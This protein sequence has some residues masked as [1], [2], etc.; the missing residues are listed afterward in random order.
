MPD[1]TRLP[2][3]R[4]R[5]QESRF[6]CPFHDRD[7]WNV[8]PLPV[9]EIVTGWSSIKNYIESALPIDNSML[10]LGVGFVIYWILTKIRPKRWPYAFSWV[11][12]V[13]AALA[14]EIMDLLVE[15]WPDLIEQYSE[16]LNDLFWT[17]ALPTVA[18]WLARERPPAQMLGSALPENSYSKQHI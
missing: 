2:M 11:G 7:L 5:V 12:T 10:H 4:R 9:S 18:L 13:L 14:N 15:R 6:G 8:M 16:G 1:L 17:L 3:L